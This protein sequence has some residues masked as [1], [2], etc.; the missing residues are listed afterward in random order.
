MADKTKTTEAIDLWIDRFEEL[1]PNDGNLTEEILAAA[2]G[3][4]LVYDTTP[5]DDA[6]QLHYLK[7]STQVFA[8][9]YASGMAKNKSVF[10]LGRVEMYLGVNDVHRAA[11]ERASSNYW[12]VVQRWIEQS[13]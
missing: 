8:R 12:L 1:M 4:P 9:S 10:A 3:L 13:Y 7:R 6:E 2:G 5:T 11:R